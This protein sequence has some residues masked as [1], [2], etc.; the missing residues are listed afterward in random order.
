MRSLR[1]DLAQWAEALPRRHRA[2]QALINAW[3]GDL[4]LPLADGQEMASLCLAGLALEDVDLV[5]LPLSDDFGHIRQ[6]DL[7]RNRALT[8][9]PATLLARFPRLYALRLADCRLSHLPQV[10]TATELAWLDL[11]GNRITWNAGAQACLERYPNLRLL[12]L[13]ENPLIDAP[14]ITR[15]PLLH[16]LHLVGCSLTQLPAGLARLSR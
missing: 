2:A 13:S 11:Q 16:S 5:S 6:L 1:E 12:D 10:A 8:Q 15:L 14:D 9:L 4:D 7:S 3:R